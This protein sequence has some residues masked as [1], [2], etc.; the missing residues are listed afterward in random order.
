MK[1]FL[2][3][4][5]VITIVPTIAFPDLTTITP[6][7]PPSNASA[8]FVFDMP[9]LKL[10]LEQYGNSTSIIQ[11]LRSLVPTENIYFNTSAWTL[12]DN[13]M[14]K[15]LSTTITSAIATSE[16]AKY[17]AMLFEPMTPRDFAWLAS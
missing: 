17:G 12:V 14:T 16:C 8:L 5:W 4:L 15:I 9:N 1:I 13:K 10:I 2:P 6:K 3:I 7:T 11:D